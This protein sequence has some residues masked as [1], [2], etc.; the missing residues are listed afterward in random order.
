MSATFGFTNGGVGQPSP[1]GIVDAICSR[2]DPVMALFGSFNPMHAMMITWALDPGTGN[3][4]LYCM[5]PDTG[6]KKWDYYSVLRGFGVY[7]GMTSVIEVMDQTCTC[8][9]VGDITYFRVWP[10]GA[11]AHMTYWIANIRPNEYVG[12]YVAD[13]PAGPAQLIDFSVGEA[14][15]DEGSWDDVYRFAGSY[16]Y[17]LAYDSELPS[18]AF[19]SRLFPAE[20]N[21]VYVSGASHETMAAPTNVLTS[22]VPLDYGEALRISWTLSSDDA[23]IDRYNVYKREYPIGGPA[24]GSWQLLQSTTPGVHNCYDWHVSRTKTTEYRVSAAHHGG[25]SIQPGDGN[26]GIFNEYSSSV[27]ASMPVSNFSNF[28]L[29]LL[30]GEPSVTC[31]MGD[32]GIIADTIS[33]ELVVTGSDGSPTAG[34]SAQMLELYAV[35][36]NAY[37]CDSD[38][39]VAEHDTDAN[40]RTEFRV[41]NVGGHGELMLIAGIAG[42]VPLD[43]IVTELKSPDKDGGGSVN[44]IDFQAFGQTWEMRCDSTAYD[45]WFDF[46]NDCFVGNVDFTVFGSHWQHHCDTGGQGAAPLAAQNGRQATAA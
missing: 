7:G 46:D 39:V 44:N 18:S 1:G 32:P 27:V 33:V 3:P 17:F 45:E 6:E 4:L 10:N 28:D 12:V 38:T 26:F 36:D 8:D 20:G 2:S 41:A 22:D 40:G 15:W 14:P 25:L 23:Q 9:D 37:F 19:P 35:Y 5:D 13:N 24:N 31:P 30:S 11:S 34:A 43:T 16:Y 42:L 21:P 29:T